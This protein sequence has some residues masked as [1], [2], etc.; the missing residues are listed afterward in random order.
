MIPCKHGSTL[1]DCL[2][3][4]MTDL[5]IVARMPRSRPPTIT[6]GGETESDVHLSNFTGFLSRKSS[7]T[8]ARGSL[9]DVFKCTNTDVTTSE[10]HEEVAVKCIRLDRDIAND[11][12]RARITPRIL[13]EIHE[14]IKLQH[15]SILS[16]LGFT[17]GF[18]LLPAMV[19]PW[20]MY[21]SLTTY[22]EQR[23]LELT[24]EYKLRILRQ[25]AGAI[26][27]LHSKGVCHENLTPNNILIDSNYNAH[28]T[29]HGILAMC[30]E[31]SD[32]SHVMSNVRWAA[33]ELFEVPEDEESSTIPKAACDIYSFGCVM[34]QVLTGQLPY[35][36]VE[37][38]FRVACLK[39]KGEKP[40]RPSSPYVTD[41]FWSFMK[42]CWGDPGRR[43]S[44]V[45][46]LSCFKVLTCTYKDN[47]VT[48]DY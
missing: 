33:P 19:Y 28:V 13:C 31:L 46:I 5:D 42:R 11:D 30:S 40:S 24:I 34:I 4:T 36:N 26:S 12:S 7:D 14:L 6:S 8:I 2:A 18:G 37:S 32:T 1:K 45:E 10:C 43:P 47:N 41:F 3:Y 23:F 9:G 16:P 15:E 29:D 35:A 22:L 17:Y 27:Y 38:D 21:G 39:I 48:N 44:A 25:V 20:M